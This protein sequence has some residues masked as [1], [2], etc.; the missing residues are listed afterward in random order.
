MA[1]RRSEEA[2]KTWMKMVW[3]ELLVKPGDIL[4]EKLLKGDQ[5]LLKKIA[6]IFRD[7]RVM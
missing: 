1:C 7:K 5:I 2:T 3:L 6:S 4:V